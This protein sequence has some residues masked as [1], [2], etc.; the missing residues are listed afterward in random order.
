MAQQAVQGLLQ[1]PFF[2]FS[3]EVAPSSA[4]TGMLHFSTGWTSRGACPMRSAMFTIPL[5][6]LRA[7][8]FLG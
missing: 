7:V 2:N 4:D 1:R 5:K 3:G 8:R 6:Q